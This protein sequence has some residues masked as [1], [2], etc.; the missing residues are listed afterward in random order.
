MM[1]RKRFIFCSLGLALGVACAAAQPVETNGLR[2]TLVLIIRHAEKPETGTDLIPAGV[3]RANAYVKYFKNFTVDSKPLKLDAI[4]AAA[5]TKGSHRSRLTTEP[6]AAALGMTLDTRF[7]DKA[8][9]EF[10]TELK[11]KPHGKTILICWHHGGIPGLLTSLGADPAKLLP[12]GKWPDEVF[13]W[14]IQLRFDQDG[15][16]IPA[17]TKCINENLMPGDAAKQSLMVSGR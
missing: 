10:I 9:E 2:N 6:L 17:E 3:E 1:T 5:D 16:L 15:R 4:F 8:P 12:G 7:K 13:G 11:S 14:M